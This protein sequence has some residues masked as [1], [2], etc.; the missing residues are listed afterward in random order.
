MKKYCFYAGMLAAG[1][2]AFSSCSK[3]EEIINPNQPGAEEEAA[4]EIILQVANTGDGLTTKAGRPL[5]SSEAKQS[6]DKVKVVILNESNAVVAV[7]VFDN[8]M[9]QSVEYSTNGHGRQVT[10]KLTGDEKLS[11]GNTYK[12]Y[13]IGWHSED[14]DYTDWT[15]WADL[16]KSE[17]LSNGLYNLTIND[18][19]LGEEVFAGEISEI[20]VNG[21]GEFVNNNLTVGEENDFN[22]LT[23]HR[24]VS[25]TIGYFTSIPTK[26]VGGS[27]A[28]DINNLSLRLVTRKLHRNVVLDYFNSDFTENPTNENGE[29]VWYVVNGYNISNDVNPT[30]NFVTGT[31]NITNANG[32][33]GDSKDAC[34]IYSINLKDWFPNGDA[35]ND[36][37][38]DIGDYEADPNNWN[39]PS[40]VYGAEF[41]PGSVFAGTFLIPVEKTPN[42]STLQLQLVDNTQTTNNDGGVIRYWN[43]NLSE[44]DPQLNPKAHIY[45]ISS[46]GTVTES[47]IDE[48]RDSY[49][50]VRNHLYT[51]GAKATDDYNPGTDEP[52]DLSK[53]QNLILK[54]NDNWEMI[55]KMEIE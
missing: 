36:G 40:N 24:Q 22:V 9:N 48:Q 35:N 41:E 44:S 31:T 34:V 14:S 10:W 53:G 32:S 23:L 5:F 4:Q 51:I 6:I 29:N 19:I 49:S 54:V 30:V 21:D 16:A 3:D 26:A 55:H 28:S 27:S 50:L 11:S 15:T 38:L 45:T 33:T 12:V 20:E 37:L 7:K 42:N 46:D 39:T 18:P 2:I 52:E 13:A 47:N 17:S 1:M 8:W 43:I 25:G